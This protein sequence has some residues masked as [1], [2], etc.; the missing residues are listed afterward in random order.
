MEIR[1]TVGGNIR[2]ERRRR[3]LSQEALAFEAGV[4]QAYVS[5]VERGA[6]NLTLSLIERFANALDLPPDRLLRP[7]ER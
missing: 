1:Q 4:D 5:I 6:G 7:P 3:A 2:Q